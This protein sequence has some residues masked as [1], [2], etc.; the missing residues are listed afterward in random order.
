MVSGRSG[1][2]LK[3]AS[4]FLNSQGTNDQTPRKG[5][6]FKK[7]KRKDRDNHRKFY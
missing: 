2:G 7:G 5:K 4:S 3:S 6:K 1:T